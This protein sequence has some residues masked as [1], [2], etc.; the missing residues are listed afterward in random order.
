MKRTTVL[1]LTGLGMLGLGAT[2]AVAQGPNGSAL[3]SQNCSPCHGAKGVPSKGMVSVY[4]GLK[5]LGDSAYQASVSAD[6]IGGVIRNGFG[7]MKGYGSKFSAAE[8][9]AMAQFVKSLAP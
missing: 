7:K 4:P 5:S 1:V 2:S 3:Y 9:A 6:S 8:V